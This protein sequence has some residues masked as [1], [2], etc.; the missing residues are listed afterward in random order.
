M[1]AW[2][3]KGKKNKYGKQA[4]A[5]AKQV[6]IKPKRYMQKTR[7]RADSVIDAE[8]SKAFKAYIRSLSS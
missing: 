5:F 3:I 7:D 8:F 6:T 4:Y 2:A 1:L